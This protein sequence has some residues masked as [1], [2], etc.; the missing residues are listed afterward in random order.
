MNATPHGAVGAQAQL[1]IAFDESIAVAGARGRIRSLRPWYSSAVATHRGRS[2][3]A[4]VWLP[5]RRILAR[6]TSIEKQAK[7]SEIEQECAGA[8]SATERSTSPKTNRPRP[9]ADPAAGKDNETLP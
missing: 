8:S 6:S 5:S 2:L 7:D 9:L 1:R 3:D 4:G